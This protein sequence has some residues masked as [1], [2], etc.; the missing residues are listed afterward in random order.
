MN[1]V[2]QLLNKLGSR[3][4]FWGRRFS[5][6]VGQGGEPNQK[7][8][9]PVIVIE[10]WTRHPLSGWGGVFTETLVMPHRAHRMDPR[11]SFDS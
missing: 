7:R 5:S 2:I 1:S 8:H 3:V 10:I 4:V 6:G 11:I 9:R